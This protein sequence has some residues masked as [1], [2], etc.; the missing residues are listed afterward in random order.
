MEKNI[1]N[2]FFR[3]YPTSFRSMFMY[4]LKFIPQLKKKVLSH[5]LFKLMISE[6]LSNNYEVFIISLNF[7]SMIK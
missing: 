5:F 2:E 6:I 7:R 4:L 3:E 1:Y